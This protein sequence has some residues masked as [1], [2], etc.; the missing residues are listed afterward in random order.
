MKIALITGATSGIGEACALKFAQEN[1]FVLVHGRRPNNTEVVEK[2][3][4]QGGKAE[5][6]QADFINPEETEKMFT[7]IK[8]K[9][10]KIDVLVNNAGMV[11]RKP[12]DELTIEDFQDLFMVNL[13]APFFCAREA[14]H[15]GASAIVNVGS[16]RGLRSQATTP[17]YSASKAGLHNMTASLAKKFGPDCRVNCVAPGF[18]RTPLHESNLERLNKE[19]DQTPLKTYADPM[20][21]A[22]AVYF[23]ASDKSRF[24]TGEV[25]I[26]DGGRSLI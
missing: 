19:A 8:E 21:I 2:I 13:T 14:H 16:M 9:W 4:Y 17:A 23:L 5:Y 1:Y 24:T 11:N 20:D 3:Q 18:T 26:V 22:E 12:D 10:G 25:M 15:L 7:E 6:L